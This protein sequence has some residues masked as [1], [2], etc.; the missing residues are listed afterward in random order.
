M[1]V[2]YSSCLRSFKILLNHGF[3]TQI[4]TN[5]NQ[6]SSKKII[7]LKI[8]QEMLYARHDKVFKNILDK[9]VADD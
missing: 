7:T 5:Q 9:P 1:F 3:N 6:I 8:V 2:E 4:S